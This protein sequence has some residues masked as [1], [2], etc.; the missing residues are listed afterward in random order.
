MRWRL[1]YSDMR[2]TVSPGVLR[3][4]ECTMGV[5]RDSTSSTPTAA[6]GVI[7]VDGVRKLS[8]VG[9]PFVGVSR[10]YPEDC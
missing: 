4:A 7:P 10:S 3:D 2:F 8:K 6:I 1:F 5:L 9:N